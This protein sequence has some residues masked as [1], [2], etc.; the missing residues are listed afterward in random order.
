MNIVVLAGGISTERDV[1]LSSGAMIYRAL[2][3]NGHKVILLDVYLGYSGED[4]DT[5][6]DKEEVE[7][8][9]KSDWYLSAEKCVEKK[10]YDGIITSIYDLI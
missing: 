5:I 3:K 9:M 6:F 1:S 10:V 4:I 7:E 2:Q 8:K